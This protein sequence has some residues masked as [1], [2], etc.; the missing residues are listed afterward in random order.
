MMS[1]LMNFTLVDG[2]LKLNSNVPAGPLLLNEKVAAA[3]RRPL[4]LPGR[5][6]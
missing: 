1:L 4:P 5:T 6:T 2:S 3:V